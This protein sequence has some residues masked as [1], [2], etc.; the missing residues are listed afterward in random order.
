M[1]IAILFISSVLIGACTGL[2]AASL[3][4]AKA[5]LLFPPFHMEC[6]SFIECQ[7]I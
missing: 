7:D 6:V 2:W 4:S 1:R 3:E 5:D